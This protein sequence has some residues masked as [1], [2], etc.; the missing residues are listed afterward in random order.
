MERIIKSLII[1]LF[2]CCINICV[3]TVANTNISATMATTTDCI[4]TFPIGYKKLYFLT[5][6]ATTQYNYEIKEIQTKSGFII[7]TDNN[8]KT[9]LASIIY[10]SSAKSMLK[11]TPCD[12]T[13]NFTVNTPNNIF[14]YVEENLTK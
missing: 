3:P 9:F 6:S 11:I 2:I 13:Y 8:N 1:T 7:F 12:N 5:L 14:N 4:K 10:V